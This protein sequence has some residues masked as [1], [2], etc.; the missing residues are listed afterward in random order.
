MRSRFHPIFSVILCGPK[1]A[2]ATKKHFQNMETS[3]ELEEAWP[4][5]QQLYQEIHN[6]FMEGTKMTK[7]FKTLL[8]SVSPELVRVDTS[9]IRNSL[10]Q[11]NKAN[12]ESHP[13][14]GAGTVLQ[15]AVALGSKAREEYVLE[16]LQHGYRELLI[17]LY[18]PFSRHVFVFLGV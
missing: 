14:A 11:L 10:S 17:Y 5:I 1:D 12:S 4:T 9:L 8:A 15:F 3:P 7:L 18:L 6:S 16:L 2:I 13:C